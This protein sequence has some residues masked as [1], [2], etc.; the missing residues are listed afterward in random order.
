MAVRLLARER[1]EPGEHLRV[2]QELAARCRS[3]S[4][5]GGGGVLSCW[6]SSWAGGCQVAANAPGVAA[7]PEPEPEPGLAAEGVALVPDDRQPTA[8]SAASGP[9][10]RQRDRQ[11][12]QDRAMRHHGRRRDGQAPVSTA[13]RR[14]ALDERPGGMTE[15]ISGDLVCS[16]GTA[17]SGRTRS[18]SCAAGPPCR[19]GGSRTGSKKS[20]TYVR[21]KTD[22]ISSSLAAFPAGV[23]E[24][25]AHP[26][27]LRR[28]RDRQAFQLG[29]VFPEHMQGDAADDPAV[30]VGRHEELA[31]RLVQLTQRAADHQLA[32]GERA[33][34]LVDGGHVTNAGR[35]NVQSRDPQTPGSTPGRSCLNP[36]HAQTFWANASHRIIV[37][38]RPSES[39]PLR[40]VEPLGRAFCSTSLDRIR[41]GA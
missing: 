37:N 8:R 32:I 31:D 29:E 40:G 24:P 33:D 3:W 12:R 20:E 27:P 18:R 9:Q 25:S 30:V 6:T 1:P 4:G 19:S 10:R 2:E 16:S 7:G 21:V 17:G 23:D 36:P 14:P 11:R 35:A 28:S 15:R 22:L 38:R 5:R 39:S 13:I 26:V 41:A 34:Q